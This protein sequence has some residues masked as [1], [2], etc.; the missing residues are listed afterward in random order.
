MDISNIIKYAYLSKQFYLIFKEINKMYRKIATEDNK[1]KY[2]IDK[3]IKFRQIR[4]CKFYNDC[5]DEVNMIGI[6][7][8]AIHR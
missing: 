6:K 3:L 8:L 5:L 1:N 2:L 4:M 7:Y